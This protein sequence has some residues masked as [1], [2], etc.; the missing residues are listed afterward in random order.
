MDEAKHMREASGT[1]VPA[2][3]GAWRRA[4]V[5]LAV[6]SAIV[7]LV[8]LL[9]TP[10]YATPDDFMQD[11]YARGAHFDTPGFLMLYSLVPFS[12]PLSLLYRLLPAVPWFPLVM[13]GLQA[14]SFAAMGTIALSAR[15]RRPL[16]VFLLCA[17]AICEV[18]VTAYFTYTIVAFVTF[19]GGVS[20][21]LARAAFV[22]PEGL[23]ASDVLAFVLIVEGFS[24]RPESGLAALAIF[25]PFLVWAIAK[26][27][28]ARTMIYALG[29]VATVAVCYGAGQ[30]AWRLT[31]GWEEFLPNLD[32]A[33]AIAD[34]PVIDYADVQRVAPQ[35]SQTDVDMIYE[36]LFV[37]SDTYTL[38][39]FRALD[40]VVEGYGLDT[41]VGGMLARPTFTAYVLGLTVILV[42]SA[43]FI[44][45]AQRYR[46]GRRALVLSIPVLAFLEFLMIF[47]RARLMIHVFLPVFVVA[48]FALVVCC[49][50]PASSEQELSERLDAGRG[51]AFLNWVVPA[52]GVAACAGALLLLEVVYVLLLQRTLQTELTPN[53]ERY[54][55]SHQDQ[56]VLF[57]STQG[58]LTNEDI[59]DFDS[60]EEPDNAV[61]LGGYEYYTPAW[62]TLLERVGLSS[63]D[64]FLENLVDSEDMVTASYES[65]AEMLETYLSEH[66]GTT[67]RAELVESLGETTQEGEPV[68]IWRYVSAE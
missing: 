64:G 30:L 3:H 47:L 67:V 45:V 61:L 28:N 44:C 62:Q 1:G 59:F 16:K 12:A 10:K 60:W 31:P 17:L 4:L 53:V 13:L 43:A 57:T 56:L 27:R 35:L 41:M 48:L 29:V 38:E 55:D 37:D 68:G 40:G 20:L 24:L 7:A 46:G 18:M 11:L 22:R 23:R 6:S 65:Q 58:I 9:Q 15:A 36:F 21:V 32:A 54:L 66:T 25:S 39:T 51:G 63:R 26:N 8:C 50:I 14:V 49:Q 34:Y 42:A 33:R 2:R 19:A 5:C 52:A